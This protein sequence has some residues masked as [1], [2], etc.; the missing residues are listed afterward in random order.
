MKTRG[1]TGVRVAAVIGATVLVLALAIDLLVLSG[2]VP[3]ALSG[4]GDRLSR[5]QLVG[6]VFRLLGTA[7]SWWAPA[8]ACLLA[9]RSR[10]GRLLGVSVLLT[11]QAVSFLWVDGLVGRALRAE[12]LEVFQG[13][14]LSERATLT[15]PSALAAL[16]SG[17][18]AAGM[19]QGW[20]VEAAT[21]SI[22]SLLAYAPLALAGRARN[23]WGFT[24][25]VGLG[26]RI[27]TAV[28]PFAFAFRP[29]SW[30]MGTLTMLPVTAAL[31]LAARFDDDRV[32][33][34]SLPFR[35]FAAA[36]GLAVVASALVSL[37]LPAADP[38]ARVARPPALTDAAGRPFDLTDLQGSVVLVTAWSP[39]CRPCARELEWFGRLRERE[40]S[41][42]LELVVVAV[43][44]TPDGSPHSL[45]TM[46]TGT[47]FTL[48][49][50]PG[51]PLPPVLPSNWLLDRSGRV[52]ERSTGFNDA[53]GAQLEASLRT[54]L[55]SR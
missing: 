12:S 3:Q 33:T 1:K 7:L 16:R 2:F 46:P 21:L 51:G 48:P 25:A 42:E 37:L 41:W 24:L 55:A 17:G 30:A 15:L 26:V 27:G 10:R 40:P 49:A 35:G 9:G 29:W 31:L 5:L 4:V 43:Q 34:R 39:T 38:M 23:S 50:N 53:K 44:S 22:W 20:L 36:A 18:E 19:A 45:R 14:L 47:H 32:G 13:V 6:A 28:L 52:V 8:F 11:V 54:L